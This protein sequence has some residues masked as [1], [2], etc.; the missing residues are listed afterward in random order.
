MAI[1]PNLKILRVKRKATR[2]LNPKTLGVQGD[3]SLGDFKAHGF[4]LA[5]ASLKRPRPLAR[6]RHW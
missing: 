2:M 6:D 4:D 5:Q 1:P 3:A